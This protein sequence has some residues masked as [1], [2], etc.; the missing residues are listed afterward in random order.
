MIVFNVLFTGQEHEQLNR[1]R[2]IGMFINISII[3]RIIC[4][5]K[6]LYLLHNLLKLFRYKCKMLKKNREQKWQLML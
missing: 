4:S 2:L 1:K 6:M 3:L 5:F